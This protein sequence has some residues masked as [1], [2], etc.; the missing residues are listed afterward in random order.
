MGGGIDYSAFEDLDV[1]C[2]WNGKLMEGLRVLRGEMVWFDLY[3]KW[4][5]LV[6]IL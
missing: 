2:E 6:G 3:F 4:I 5:V 1:D